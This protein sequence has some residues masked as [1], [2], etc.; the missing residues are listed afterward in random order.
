MIF[1]SQFARV[2]FHQRFSSAYPKTPNFSVNLSAAPQ[3]AATNR[4]DFLQLQVVEEKG[5]S[6]QPG[7]TEGAMGP[8]IAF[9]RDDD[10]TGFFSRVALRRFSQNRVMFRFDGGGLPLTKKFG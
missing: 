1:D 6:W 8:M 2:A 3:M 5:R 4:G 9:N 7:D 10:I